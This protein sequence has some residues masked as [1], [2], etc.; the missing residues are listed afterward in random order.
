MSVKF[1]FGISFENKDAPELVDHLK[2]FSDDCVQSR[3]NLALR[4]RH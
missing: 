2:V 1:E 3:V 4:L